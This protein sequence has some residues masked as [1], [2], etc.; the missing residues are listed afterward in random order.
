[1][2]HKEFSG[3]VYLVFAAV[4]WSFSGLL[5][6]SV[7]WSAVSLVCFRGILTGAAFLLILRPKKKIRW[8]FAKLMSAGCYFFQ[9]LFL[10]LAHKY[11]TAGNATVIQNISPI[12]IILMN[13][14]ILHRKP[15]KLDIL[16]CMLMLLGVVLC[17]A[18]SF[19]GGAF[20]G[21]LFALISAVFYSGVFFANSLEDAN[22]LESLMLGNFLYVL[23]LPFLFTDKAVFASTWKDICI[24]L[25][26]CLLS[27]VA[28]WYCFSKGIGKTTALSAGFAAMLEPV[29]SPVWPFLFIGECLTPLALA[30]GALVIL[31]LV[32]YNAVQNKKKG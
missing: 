18:G 32:F 3:V 6:K 22:P 9:S 31:T 20:L 15:E 11:T 26:F 16:S 13:A 7:G 29:L 28:A 4:F 17:F 23:L 10:I 27:G 21:N 30:G 12:F 14:L 24:V 2:E 5:V 19:G 25:A 8:N 1:M